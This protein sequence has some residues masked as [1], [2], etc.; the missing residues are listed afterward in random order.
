[1]KHWLGEPHPDV[2]IIFPNMEIEEAE[3]ETE[4]EKGVN[5]PSLL[6]RF[7][8]VRNKQIE[9]VNSIRDEHW[10]EERVRTAFGKVSAVF[11]VTKTIQH[12][13][14]HGNTILRNALYWDRALN[15]LNQQ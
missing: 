4:V 3:W 14:E 11:T 9:V 10:T 5:L 8:S 2:D 7:H 12:T 13:L 15:W 6:K 1:M